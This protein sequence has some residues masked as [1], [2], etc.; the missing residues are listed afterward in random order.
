M[1]INQNKTTRLTSG[2]LGIAV[3]CITTRVIQIPIPLGYAHLGNASILLFSAYFDPVMAGLVAGIG[4]AL[5]DLLS[6]PVWMIPTL[7]IK[8]V[9]G[10]VCSWIMNGKGTKNRIRRV[11]SWR[12]F[13]AV[14]FATVEM[15]IGYTIAGM[16]LYGS[17]A[18]GITQIPGLTIEGVIGIILFYVVYSVLSRYSHD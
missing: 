5:A 4:S 14:V 8:F 9:M 2:A 10:A 17:A 15:V 7:L 18:A 13:A 16:V 3:V 12:T 11:S 6:F 1:I